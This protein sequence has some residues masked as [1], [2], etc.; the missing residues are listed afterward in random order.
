[1]KGMGSVMGP[2]PEL[3]KDYAVSG[4]KRRVGQ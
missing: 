3:E 2:E 4:V 1:M